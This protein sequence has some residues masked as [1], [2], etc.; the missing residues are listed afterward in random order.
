M[1]WVKRIAT[2]LILAAMFYWAIL[3]RIENMPQVPLSLVFVTLPEASLSVWMVAAF[4]LGVVL[5]MLLNAL[6][7]MKQKTK[8]LV[9]KRQLE[10]CQQQLTKLRAGVPGD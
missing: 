5:T 7:A 3:F 4:A 9:A 6:L 10:Q 1:R 2:I 8:Y